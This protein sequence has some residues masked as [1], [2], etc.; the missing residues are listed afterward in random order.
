MPIERRK[1]GTVKITPMI[2][3]RRWLS[4]SAWRAAA[5]ASSASPPSSSASK[6]AAATARRISTWLTIVG[7]YWTRAFSVA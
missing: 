7:T 3:R 4:I 2:N 6:P 1:S 5:S